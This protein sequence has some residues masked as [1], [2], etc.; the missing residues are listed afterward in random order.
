[1]QK[2]KISY[3]KWQMNRRG[4]K[5]SRS[6]EGDRVSAKRGVQHFSALETDGKCK[7]GRI[8]FQ[9]RNGGECYT[10]VFQQSQID[11]DLD[12]VTVSSGGVCCSNYTKMVPGW[13][14]VVSALRS[15]PKTVEHCRKFGEFLQCF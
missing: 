1:L 2:Y 8:E 14:E 5:R 12:T 3:I 7:D 9:V 4:Q 11:Q 15:T 6:D 10:V 13:E